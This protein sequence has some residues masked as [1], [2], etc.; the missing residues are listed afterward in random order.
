MASSR[1]DTDGASR[2]EQLYAATAFRAGPARGCPTPRMLPSALGREACTVMARNMLP[3]RT[4]ARLAQRHEP[5]L[6]DA[7][8]TAEN[9][10]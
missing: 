7:V 9:F 1:T 5:V 10:I 3:A 8:D 4:D 2:F 6:R